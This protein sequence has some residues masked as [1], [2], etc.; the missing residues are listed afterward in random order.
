M[1]EAPTPKAPSNDLSVWMLLAVGVAFVGTLPSW[2]EVGLEALS[3]VLVMLLFFFQGVRLAPSEIRTA[4]TTPKI[5]LSILAVTFLGFPLV[6][7]GLI[8]AFGPLLDPSF[9]PGIAFLGVAP[10][11]IQSSVI[12]TSI[13]GGNVATAVCAASLS[14]SVG[15][16]LTPLLFG[17][18][19]PLPTG[20]LDYLSA[21]QRVAVGLLVPVAVGL[22]LRPRLKGFA[23][24]RRGL[25]KRLDQSAIVLIV[26]LSFVGAFRE[27][28]FSNVALSDLLV[29]GVLLALLLAGTLFA[30]R[31]L[32]ASLGADRGDRIAILF[33]ASKKSLAAGAPIAAALLSKAEVS[34]FL[35]PLMLYH[36]LQLVV[37]SWIAS[38]YARRA[39]PKSQR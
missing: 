34:R 15:V 28:I 8:R 33:C 25:L 4:L 18:S 2:L 30:C 31:I 38:A 35:L 10:S 3:R 21:M 26:Y 17:L 11:T 7:A 22:V 32:G 29:L 1:T 12:F 37:C 19:T 20:S 5:Q 36:Q 24:T 9:A 23:A 14:S 27:K 6:A 16:F 39:A 13:A